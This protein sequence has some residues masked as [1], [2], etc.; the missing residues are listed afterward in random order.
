MMSAGI[1]SPARRRRELGEDVSPRLR[2]LRPG[3]ADDEPPKMLTA[4]EPGIAR[5]ERL[6][7]RRPSSQLTR[8][9][10]KFG[11][12]L[13]HLLNQPA[14]RSRRCHLLPGMASVKRAPTFCVRELRCSSVQELIAQDEK[15]DNA[16][17][18]IPPSPGGRSRRDVAADVGP[19]SPCDR[20]SRWRNVERKSQDRRHQEH[21]REGQNQRLLITTRP[22]DG[23]SAIDSARP[24][25]SSP[26]ERGKQARMSTMPP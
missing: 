9:F 8:F 13:R 14:E 21:G 11:Q 4:S 16:D 26:P 12:R 24:G 10:L 17:H 1:W 2:Q 3:G 5:R 19:C 25:R 7:M 6:P 23:T 22:S 15:D 18:E 20:M